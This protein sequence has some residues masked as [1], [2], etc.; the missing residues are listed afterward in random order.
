MVHPQGSQAGRQT[1]AEGVW[2]AVAAVTWLAFRPF[3]DAPG[4][5]LLQEGRLWPFGR[6]T[7][8]A[9]LG[10]AVALMGF[11]RGP[12]GARF[13]WVL[14]EAGRRAR[15]ACLRPRWLVLAAVPVLWLL[16]CRVH[17]GDFARVM[18]DVDHGVWLLAAEP[19]APALF[20]LG[21][22]GLGMLGVPPVAA[23]AAV[24]VVAGATAVA[25]LF[26]L[27][28]QITS[29]FPACW[30]GV[31][32][33]LL[34]SGCS[35]LYFGHVETYTV[36]AALLVWALSLGWDGLS[37]GG[38]RRARV[39]AAALLSL[40]AAFHMAH[41]SGFA[42]LVCLS[43][44]DVRAGRLRDAARLLLV[45]LAPAGTVEAIALG[46]PSLGPAY[47]QHFGGADGVMFLASTPTSGALSRYTLGSMHHM[48][49]VANVLLLVCPIGI[50]LPICIG[51]RPMRSAIRSGP[52]CWL[53]TVALVAAGW[54]T[55]LLFWSPD[56][57]SLH[58]WDLFAAI[59][60]PLSALTATCL[61]NGLASSFAGAP[62][63]LL[64]LGLVQ[65]APCA[66]LV[67]F[68]AGLWIGAG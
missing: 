3:A 60:I 17:T 47:P 10:L 52:R 11:S 38:T 46:V 33:M 28:A 53:V 9:P 64:G 35:A 23:V 61:V 20:L 26:R 18:L 55:L 51:L 7:I 66:G 25:G 48:V 13:S 65:A 63:L 5:E 30:P 8:L 12:L 37:E 49:A 50:G 32:L 21:A 4:T 16:R 54:L 24:V 67:L 62:A 6:A 59:G 56:L 42:A 58:D 27:S 45:G 2:L 14:G 40:A 31:V 39:A 57:G 19:L 15:R 29:R 43:W 22:R 1:G 41:L 44:P 68:N 36:S 34:G